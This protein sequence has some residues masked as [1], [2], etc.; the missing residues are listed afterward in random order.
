MAVAFT[1]IWQDKIINKVE[2]VLEAEF[3]KQLKVYVA[4]EYIPHGNVSI[5]VFGLH[6]ILEDYST[7]SFTNEYSVE[8]VYYIVASNFN[9]KVSDKFYRDISRIEQVMFNNK[10]Q[11]QPNAWYNGRIEEISINDK[12]PSEELVD[13]LLTARFNFV[14]NYQHIS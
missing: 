14:C 9:E 4:E 11:A 5:R 12:T 6:Q 13:N 1:N 7:N 2:S 8:I 10:N 3:K